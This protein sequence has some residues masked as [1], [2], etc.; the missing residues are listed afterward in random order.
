MPK[1]RRKTPKERYK[2]MICEKC[3]SKKATLFYADEGGSR[4]AL[5][6]SCGEGINKI[7]EL[8][9]KKRRSGT[10]FLPERTLYSFY[11]GKSV[12]YPYILQKNSGDAVCSS[13][14]TRLEQ[15]IEKGRFCCPDCYECFEG[16][17]SLA[18]KNEKKS[19]VSRMPASRRADLD[20]LR[21][22]EQIRA[23]IKLAVANENYEL[24][25]SLHDKAKKLECRS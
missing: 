12:V 16:Y 13:C 8:G 18:D 21:A 2:K 25:A 7:S 10:N 14:N 5:C 4:H 11:D 3:K 9:D 15:I 24:A 22:L 23:E 1:V 6:A 20:R 19:A 17:L